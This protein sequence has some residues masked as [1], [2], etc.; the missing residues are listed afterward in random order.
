MVICCCKSHSTDPAKFPAVKVLF[1]AVSKNKPVSCS[2]VNSTKRLL[3]F[4]FV[5]EEFIYDPLGESFSESGGNEE[6]LRYRLGLM[7]YFQVRD[8]VKEME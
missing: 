7:K 3:T 8:S 2:T 4:E 1:I 5:G 6:S